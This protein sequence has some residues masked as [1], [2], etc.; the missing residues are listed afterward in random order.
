MQKAE[1]VYESVQKYAKADKVCQML[2]IMCEN[3]CVKS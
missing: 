2:K 3:R 1:R